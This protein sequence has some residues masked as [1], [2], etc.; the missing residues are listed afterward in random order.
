VVGDADFA[1]N[2]FFPYMSNS[3]L[4]LAMIAWLL[5]EERAPTMK[6]LVEVLPTVVLTSR[7]VHGIFL[8]AVVGLPG[9][10]VLVGGTVWWRRRR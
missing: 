7:Q 2:S 10:V 3:D 1:S 6:P 8:L 4:V 5:G 9:L